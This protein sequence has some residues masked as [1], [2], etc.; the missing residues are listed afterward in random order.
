[1]RRFGVEA[2]YGDATRPNMLHAA[3]IETAKL[4]VV[5]IDGREQITELTRHVIDK[6]PHVH[7]IARAW[8]R[9]HTFELWSVG[10]RDI[11]RETYDSAIRT[12]RT[13]LEAL[14]NSRAEAE[15]LAGA[16][17]TLDRESMV[18]IASLYQVGVPN[19]ENPEFV[20]RFRELREEWGRQ[21]SG[22]VA[23]IRR[24]MSADD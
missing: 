22:R 24:E 3:G 6:Y 7:V 5:A 2:Y 19:H 8:D 9:N 10:C 12:G 14:G 23:E 16:F 17:E 20:A 11:I 15:R 1:L 18:E 13:A 21:L 4:F